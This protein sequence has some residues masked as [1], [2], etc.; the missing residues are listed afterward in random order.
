MNRAPDAGVKASPPAWLAACLLLAAAWGAAPPTAAQTSAP[1]STPPAEAE[2]PSP[3]TLLFESPAWDR[4]PPGTHL[5]YRYTRESRD[6]S[7]GPPLTDQIA[8][9]VEPG[10]S[11]TTRTVRVAMFTGAQRA[12][13]GPFEDVSFNPAL[14]LFLEHHVGHLSRAFHANP[15]YL[16]NTIRAALRDGASVVPVDLQVGGKPVRGWRV[17]VSPFT[18]DPNRARMQGLD[19]LAYTFVAAGGVPGTLVSIDAQATAP[20]G[21]LY[22]ET[23]RYDPVAP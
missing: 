5:L 7:L 12:A 11:A 21:R 18:A 14:V 2:K 10:E 23:L 17:T 6:P 19:T 22:A 8:L 4:A 1:E 16:K 15:R 3:A 20:D 13:A 9:D